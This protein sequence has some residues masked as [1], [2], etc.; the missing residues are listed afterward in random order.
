L[1]RAWATDGNPISKRRG[2]RGKGRRGRERKREGRKKS[3]L[4]LFWCK[5]MGRGGEERARAT[6][7]FGEQK[8]RFE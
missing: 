7:A 1:K 2:H 4:Q 3:L 8:Q 5:T 6:V